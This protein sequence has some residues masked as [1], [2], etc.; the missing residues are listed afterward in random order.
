MNDLFRTFLSTLATSGTF[1]PVNNSKI[2][3]Y[4][5]SIK[6]AL[7]Y[8]DHAADTARLADRHNILA[9]IIGITL[10]GIWRVIWDQTDDMVRTN[11]YT[12]ATGHTCFPINFCD[13]IFNMNRIEWTFL[14][15]G[16]KS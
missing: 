6:F 7:F 5:Y 10:Y 16:S 11:G 3:F 13:S 8:A 2:I 12:F 9:F 15:T 4:F 14:H 1:F